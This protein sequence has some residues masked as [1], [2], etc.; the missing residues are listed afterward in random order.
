[1]LLLLFAIYVKPS[2]AFG[3]AQFGDLVSEFMFFVTISSETALE[4]YPQYAL[5]AA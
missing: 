3:A 2:G 4:C 1:M 5:K